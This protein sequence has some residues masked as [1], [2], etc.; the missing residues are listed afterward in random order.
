MDIDIAITQDGK[1][2]IFTRSGSFSQGKDALARLLKEL[3][4]DGIELENISPVEQHR[5]QHQQAIVSIKEK[6]HAR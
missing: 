4:A 5:H 2:S 6:T 1:I 3:E